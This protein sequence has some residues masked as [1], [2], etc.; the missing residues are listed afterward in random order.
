M[1]PLAALDLQRCSKLEGGTRQEWFPDLAQGQGYQ[2]VVGWRLALQSKGGGVG[3]DFATLSVFL[4][5]S[6]LF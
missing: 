1:R 4:C 6:C 5:E 3:L 2:L